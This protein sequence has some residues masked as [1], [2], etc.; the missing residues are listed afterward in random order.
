MLFVI[1]LIADRLVFLRN[2]MNLIFF[3]SSIMYLCIRKVSSRAKDFRMLCC[4]IK[5]FDASFLGYIEFS[6]LS[7]CYSF[8]LLTPSAFF[9]LPFFIAFMRMEVYFS[10]WISVF[11]VH[12]I[13]LL[14]SW[15]R[16]NE[17][18]QMKFI[19]VHAVSE[20]Y[21]IVRKIDFLRMFI[22][23]SRYCTFQAFEKS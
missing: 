20:I 11:K 19:I 14:L 12:N 7:Q 15:C 23:F 6:S 2:W 1:A 10:S 22:F 4:Y 9:S 18:I 5:A 16:M 8:P 21:L 13:I 17:N 3:M